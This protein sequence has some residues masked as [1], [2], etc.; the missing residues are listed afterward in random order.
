MPFQPL[1][2][3][4]NLSRFPAQG[5]LYAQAVF[6]TH[7]KATD[8]AVEV[9]GKYGIICS[10]QVNNLIHPRNLLKVQ[11]AVFLFYK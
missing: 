2:K 9:L 8:I 10:V 3:V 7:V 6:V 4:A 5:R 11:E 1:E